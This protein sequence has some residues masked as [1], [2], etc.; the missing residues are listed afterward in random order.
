MKRVRSTECGAGAGACAK[1]TLALAM[2]IS[3]ACVARK[4]SSDTSR[5]AMSNSTTN[6]GEWKALFDGS[7]TTAWRGYK[8]DTMPSGWH[9]ADGTLT[10]SDPT[11]DIVTRDTFGDFELE[12]EWKIGKGGNAGVFYRGNEDFERIYF[13]GPEYQLLDDDNH[14]DGK[15]RMT[16]AGSA[17]ALYPSPPG[18]LNPV[19]EWNRTR[20]VARG[21][22]VEHWLNGAKLLEYELWSPDWEAR[23]RASKFAEWAPQYGR[24]KSGHI[25]I[26]GDHDGVLALRNIRIRELH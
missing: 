24:L 9:I 25:G 23:Y 17:F 5:G 7:S 8:M 20:I 19:G 12:L 26:Q 4:P 10:K 15:L 3:V 14:P 21:A 13:T 11:E 6:S 18:H 16:S 22:H 2:L 1:V